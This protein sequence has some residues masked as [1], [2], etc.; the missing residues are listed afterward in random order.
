MLAEFEILLQQAIGLNPAAIGSSAIERAVKTRMEVCNCQDLQSYREH[1]HSSEEELQ[2]LIEEVV[3]SETWFF[4]DPEAFTAMVRVA[5]REWLPNNDGVLRLLSLP[6]STG[7]EPYSMIMA[8]LDG[9]FPSTRFHI[10]AI[11]VSARVLRHAERALYGR[12]AFRG[13]ELG[14]RQR[15]FAASPYG[16]RLTGSLQNYVDFERAN[17]LDHAFL[18]SVATY[19]IVFCRNLLIY[20]DSDAQSRALRV[21]ARALTARGF[22]FVGPSEAN[23]LLSHGFVPVKTPRAFAFHKPT[24]PTAD[25][26]EPAGALKRRPT[27]PQIGRPQIR[28]SSVT[29]TDAA[30]QRSHTINLPSLTEIQSIADRGDLAEAAR[31]CEQFVGHRNS[32]AD[33]LHLLGLI[34]DASGDWSRAAEHYRKA[35][36]SDPQHFDS[37]VHLALLLQKNGDGAGAQLLDQRIRRLH[38]AET[39]Q[40]V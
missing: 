29:K 11:D 26:A 37:L 7:E 38:Q 25:V 31:H 39:K 28:A 36:Y 10:D 3:I 32:S 2:Q 27:L 8:L 19:D 9:G 20:F 21:L 5:H 12:N 14:F 23:L 34:H 30:S 13:L 35:L 17:L 18:P 15:Y 33:A 6:C 16:H 24:T 22:L 40:R 1:M 4:R